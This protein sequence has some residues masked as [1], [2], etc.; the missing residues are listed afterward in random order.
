MKIW[1]DRE[2]LLGEGGFGMVYKGK[3]WDSYGR[4]FKGI[5]RG[6]EVAVKRILIDR[7][8]KREEEAMLKLDHPNIVKLLHCEKDQDFKYYALE[9]C[10][11]SLDQLFLKSEDPKKYKGPMPRAIEIFYQLATGLAYIHSKG[12]IH[13][14]IKPENILIMRKPGKIEEIIIKWSD[15]GLAKSVNEKGYHSWTGVRGTKTWWAP[16]VLE[17]LLGEE[18]PENEE[19]W[20]IVKSDVFVLGLVFGYI[21]SE[22]KHL[23]G[24][25]EKEIHDNIIGKDPVN[26]K[27]IDGE[28]RKYYED[29]LLRKMLEYDP[30]KRIS[31]AEVVKQL[32]LIYKKLE[33]K[34]VEFL[35]LC[36]KDSSPGLLGRI[37][38]FIRLGIDV[39]AKDIYEK[40]N[41]LHYLCKSNPSPNL[42]VA[43][44]L[45]IQLGIDVIAKDYDRRNA[46]HYLCESNSTPNLIDA[47]QLLIQ[48]GIDVNAK[49]RWGRN[50]LCYLCG[51][52]SSPNL[53]DAIQL[54]IPLGI[55]V[56]A[57]DRQGE[58]ALHHLCACSSS[59][60]LI[61]AIQL[62]I[63]LGIDVNAKSHLGMNALHFL[64]L[65]NSNPNLID[66]AQLLIQLEIDVNA[67][68]NDGRNALHHLCQSNSSPNLIDAIQLLI[69]QG[70]DVNAKDNDGRNALHYLCESNSSPNLIDAIQ[71]LIQLGI[72]VNAKD[73]RSWNALHYFCWL[74]SSP[75]LID[76]IQ[77]LIQLGI[78]VNAKDT[79][80]TNAQTCL[81][82]RHWIRN[83]DEILK[84]FDATVV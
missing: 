7:A 76:A 15:F 67:K 53:I 10:E 3:L 29:D 26:M 12:L 62:L 50:A 65:N 8:D 60:N 80:G 82:N 25:H 39:K 84:L 27:D 33:K 5:F 17:K 83:K 79:F 22:G 32:A 16:E 81:R 75:N 13:R 6:R 63:Q 46:L 18:K 77:L 59:L 52:N 71:L 38:D 78:D 23:F 61:N 49:D 35:R 64:C 47:I 4:I 45:L 44:Q 40:R 36:A 1:I 56:N 41:A 69:Q 58:T 57:K 2:K 30:E 20:G 9:L 70:I 37:N 48:L 73:N 31:S 54:L 19:Y 68:D 34:E 21:F 11:A 55:N 74:N 51:S 43:I 72:D 66:A 14:D 28:L 24:S 42:I